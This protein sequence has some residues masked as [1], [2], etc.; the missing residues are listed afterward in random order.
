MRAFLLQ[1]DQ[2]LSG[3]ARPLLVLAAVVGVAIVAF[4]DYATGYEISIAVFY[5]VPC[6][7]AAWYA[8][9]NAGIGMAALSCVSWLAADILSGHPYRDSAIAYWN[10]VVR[11]GF[12][13]VTALLIAALRA[14]LERQRSLARADPLTGAYSRRAFVERLGH[15]LEIARRQKRPLTLMLF[16]LDNFK[17]LND[18]FGHVAG[19]EALRAV[20]QALMRGRRV[21][22]TAARFGGDE[23]ALVLPDTARAGAQEVAER[24]RGGLRLALATSPGVTASLGIACFAEAPADVDEAVRKADELLYEAKRK[25]RDAVVFGDA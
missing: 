6:A 21:V 5:L 22:D 4:V 18:T 3:L 20:A 24:V 12:F 9:R 7:L 15:D 17:A 1:L 14:S 10:A 16:D 8:G 19:D 2:Q 13:L 25:G 11:L 23:F